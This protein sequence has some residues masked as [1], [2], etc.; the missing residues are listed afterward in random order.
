M[1]KIFFGDMPKAIYNTEVYF[2][3]KYKDNWLIDPITQEMIKSI[4]K[5]T[6]IGDKVIDS[7]YLGMIPPTA[8]SG[9]VKTL[10]L[11]RNEPKRVF[12]AS[13]CGDNCADWLLRLAENDD[14][15][16]NL[17]HIMDFGKNF[18]VYVL[19]EKKKVDNMRD[20]ILIAGKYV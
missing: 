20:L 13:T 4:D 5:S 9:G 12:N 10:I 11:I 19:N 14:I 7:P 18:E 16:V 2:K 17:N 8:L 3:N 15:T 1:L 6:V